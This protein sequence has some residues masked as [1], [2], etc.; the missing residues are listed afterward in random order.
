MPE[1]R[2]SK[3][4]LDSVTDAGEVTIVYTGALAWGPLRLRLSSLLEDATARHSLR[5]QPEPALVGDLLRWRSPALQFEGQWRAQ[6]AAIRETVY[7]GP[8]GV[9]DWHCLMPRAAATLNGR[10]GGGYA[11]RLH[12]T[13]P[14]W[15]LPLRTLRWGRFHSRHDWL[16]WIDWQGDFQQRIVYHNGVRVQAGHVGDERL[17]LPG[18]G[19]LRLDCALV[20]RQGPL[21]ALPGV[22]N[23]PAR[24]LR[25]TECKWRSRGCLERP[26][27]AAAPGWAI[28]EHVEW[29]P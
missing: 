4:Y 25:V 27:K 11:E 8:H 13:A 16:V 21:A 3:W 7:A 29:P 9:V 20:L 24:L 26:G 23:L 1:F 17:E 6:A 14:P 18:G 22:D 5:R 12:M 10:S 19:C 2:L 15:A 28:H